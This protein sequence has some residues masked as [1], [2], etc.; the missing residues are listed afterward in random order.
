VKRLSWHAIATL[1]LTA[2]ILAVASCTP[3]SKPH[4]TDGGTTVVSVTPGEAGGMIEDKFTVSAT[5]SA[6]NSSSRSVTLT[7][8][9]GSK[10]TFKVP[11]EVRNF[12]Q[13]N[14]GDKVSATISERMVV[15]VR[16]GGADPSVA[17]A[18]ALAAAPKGAKPGAMVAE[19][20]EI[21][22][23][24]TSI[25]TAKRTAMLQFA[26]GQTRTV[27]VRA[28]VDMSRYKVGD[29]VVIRVT[30]T[31]SVLVEKP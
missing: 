15:F 24:I 5:I 10:A 26:D 29:S 25:D 19:T 31:L 28:D 9:D 22:A 3:Q 16:S 18:A 4:S 11:P 2:G 1:L 20:Y 21:V 8:D 27:P 12:D 6:V 7:G 14:R 23:T 17:R 13:I 30:A